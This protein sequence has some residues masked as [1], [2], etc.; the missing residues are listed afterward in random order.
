MLSSEIVI[1]ILNDKLTTFKPN[2]C[3]QY[4]LDLY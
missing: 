1:L 3:N 4:T 2:F